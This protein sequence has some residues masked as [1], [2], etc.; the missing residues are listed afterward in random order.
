M[1]NKQHG[2]D[3]VNLKDLL[4]LLVGYWKLIFLVTI[5]STSLAATY[6]FLATPVYQAE[7]LLAPV[8]KDKNTRLSAL[9]GQ[10]SGLASLA[11]V[12]V[13][14]SGGS[15]AEAIAIL[16]S[17]DLTYKL[18]KDENLLP[19]LFEK[20]WD[21]KKNEWIGNG[22]SPSLWKAYI[23]FNSL[24]KI[25]QNKKTGLIKL[26]INWKDPALAAKW[27]SGL[28]ASVNK[29]LRLDAIRSSEKSIKYLYD[30]LKKTSVIKV[31]DSIYS[32]I[33]AQTK[34]MMLAKTRN[35][36]AFRTLDAAVVPEQRIKPRRGLIVVFGFM[37]GGILGLLFVFFRRIFS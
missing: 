27:V 21:A 31:K 26:T 10:F 12:N 22:K 7:A 15:V 17:R 25:S 9:A 6:A 4:R 8:V 34:N 32:L 19:I 11:G 1:V 3:E 2:D 29:K 33:E 18:I 35:E 20:K 28:I 16:K 37:L 23:K 13:G 30:E 36:Y 24:R 14:G 5:I